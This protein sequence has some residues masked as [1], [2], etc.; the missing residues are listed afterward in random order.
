MLWS[1]SIPQLSVEDANGKISELRIVAGS[2]CGT[3]APSPPPNSWAA[4]DESDIETW[5]LS[6]APGAQLT[7]PPANVA[8]QR[9]LYFYQGDSVRLADRELREQA[10]AIVVADWELLVEAGNTPTEVLILQGRPLEELVAHSGP[11]V[12]NT[13]E[14]PDQAMRDYR[15]TQ[16]GGWPFA[17][18]DPVHGR[19]RG[20]FAVHADGRVEEP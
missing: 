15:Q 18:N 12:V 20:R 4:H 16:F 17:S 8:S 2:Y 6:M 14:Q 3:A 1:D 5:T 7:L 11:F 9:V 10:G 13:R 19:E